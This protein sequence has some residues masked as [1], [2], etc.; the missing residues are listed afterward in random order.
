MPCQLSQKCQ[1]SQANLFQFSKTF[2]PEDPKPSPQER[3]EPAKSDAAGSGST[4]S[5]ITG[6]GGSSGQSHTYGPIRHTSFGSNGGTELIRPPAL[7]Q[8]D[9]HEVLD[10]MSQHGSKRSQSPSHGDSPGSKVPRTTEVLLVE[11]L[12]AESHEHVE[13]LVASFLRKKLQQELPQSNNPPAL[14]ERI[15]DATWRTIRVAQRLGGA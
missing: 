3:R 12:M 11:A 6:N 1:P 15:D 10:E 4:M 14:Q 2:Q 13:S 7:A 8:E 9:L 5:A